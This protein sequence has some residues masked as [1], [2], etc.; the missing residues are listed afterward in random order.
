MYA[1]LRAPRALRFP[2]PASRA[3]RPAPSRPCTAARPPPPA[4]F[5]QLD[6]RI[7]L[8]FLE[9]FGRPKPPGR[10]ISRRSASGWEPSATGYAPRPGSWPRSWRPR[11]RRSQQRRRKSQAAL[12]RAL[13]ASVAT[14]AAQIPPWKSRS[15]FSWLLTPTRTSSPP[16]RVPARCARRG[17]S[18]RSATAGPGSPPQALACLAGR[19]GHPPVRQPYRP[20]IPLGRQQPAP[21]RPLRFA[22][23]TRHASPW[24]A[25]IYHAARSRGK[26]HPH[27]VRITARAWTGIIWRCW[28][29]G[30]A[31]TPPSTTPSSASCT[32]KPPRPPAPPRRRT[33]DS[34]DHRRA[35]RSHRRPVSGERPELLIRHGGF[36]HRDDFT[37]FV[38]TGTSISDGTT[39]MAWIDWHAALSALHHGSCPPA[40][41]NDASSP[42]PPASPKAFPPLCVTRS[43]AWI[44]GT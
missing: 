32:S 3:P 36:L 2:H 24:A 35:A 38:S 43:P 28:Q 26:D 6:S 17:C 18:P 4:P 8:A 31:S 39:L 9:R 27:A 14:L 15:P 11:R 40:A 13:T 7:S 12:T 44:P 20:R 10:W 25:D 21:R 29:E 37:S 19:A 16:C 5:Y 34:R 41:E 30:T 1:T 23:D 42:S 22:S 33:G